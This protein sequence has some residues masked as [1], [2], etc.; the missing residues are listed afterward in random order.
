M[1]TTQTA[2]PIIYFSVVTFAKLGTTTATPE[3]RQCLWPAGGYAINTPPFALGLSYPKASRWG[4]WARGQPTTKPATPFAGFYDG[5][6]ALTCAL[7]RI[8]APQ[9]WSSSAASESAF[10]RRIK[11]LTSRRL[12]IALAV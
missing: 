5:D 2:M 8:A 11:V 7:R 9:I 3:G 1:T 4:F 10:I 12:A 6:P